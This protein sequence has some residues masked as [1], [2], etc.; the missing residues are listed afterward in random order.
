MADSI[1]TLHAEIKEAAGASLDPQ[2]HDPKSA[3]DLALEICRVLSGAMAEDRDHSPETMAVAVQTAL[4]TL[5]SECERNGLCGA[6]MRIALA[7]SLL[8]NGRARVRLQIDGDNFSGAA[9]EVDA[10]VH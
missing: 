2:R 5:I 4:E 7:K 10:S 6:G 1:I 9:H 8:E 3:R